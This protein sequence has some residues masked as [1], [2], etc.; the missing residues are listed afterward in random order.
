MHRKT[1]VT[2]YEWHF[3]L[4]LLEHVGRADATFLEI[5][6]LWNN[7]KLFNWRWELDSAV[8][9]NRKIFYFV[10]HS[11]PVLLFDYQEENQ[12]MCM[13]TKAKTN[14]EQTLENEDAV[15]KFM[16]AWDLLSK[17]HPQQRIKQIYTDKQANAKAFLHELQLAL[18][19]ARLRASIQRDCAAA[20]TASTSA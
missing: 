16:L 9:S 14:L 2:T 18:V 19:N 13:S 7:I 3:Q 11:M 4:K 12:T 1:A 8:V 15:R 6:A 20:T 17:L 5:S 10:P